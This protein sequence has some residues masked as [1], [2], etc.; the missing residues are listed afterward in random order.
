MKFKKI[1]KEYFVT[2]LDR[3]TRFEPAKTRIE[4]VV[5][6]L[7]SKFYIGE[8]KQFSISEKIELSQNILNYTLAEENNDFSINEILLSL[9]KKYFKFD[10]VSYQ[11]L[12]NRFNYLGLINEIQINQ[13]TPKNVVWL[14]NLSKNLNCANDLN[15][16]REENSLLFPIEKIIL[17]EGQTESL[18]LKS[19]FNLYGYNLDKQGVLVVAAG[20]KNQVA[21]KYY[22]M[23]EYLNLPIFVLLDSDAAETQALIDPKLRK[24]DKIYLIQSG[25]FED[26]IPINIL[27][28]TLNYVHNCEYN[29]IY[30]DFFQEKSMVKNL[31]LIYKKY[32]FGEFKKAQF[33]QELKDYIQANSC[34]DDFKNSEIGQILSS[35]QD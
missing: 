31:E 4:R 14:K 25:E 33:A 13:N 23:I 10:E 28:N 2:I 5:N 32:G 22:E 6:D 7:I 26:L 29:C 17:C 3:L 12:S 11:C 16:L 24:G 30:D 18:L 27:K 15:K 20:G 19:L 8:N 9:E 35:L 21:K 1:P 34:K